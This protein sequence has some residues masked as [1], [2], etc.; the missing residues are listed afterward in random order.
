MTWSRIFFERNPSLENVD[1]R[2]IS[3]LQH[4]S[5]LPNLSWLYLG[6]DLAAQ[7]VLL[8]LAAA[9]Q[10]KLLCLSALSADAP[11]PAYRTTL[12]DNPSHPLTSWSSSL[13][14]LTFSKKA[15][16]PLHLERLEINQVDC[17]VINP[18]QILARCAALKSFIINPDDSAPLDI[19]SVIEQPWACVH[20]EALHMPLML[21]RKPI[22]VYYDYGTELASEED[23]DVEEEVEE[24][25]GEDVEEDGD[26]EEDEEDDEEER[27]LDEIGAPSRSSLHAEMVFM[28]RLST[29]TRL[30]WLRVRPWY[31]GRYDCMMWGLDSGLG[32]H[33]YLTHLEELDIGYR[34]HRQEEREIQWM[35]KNWPKLSKLVV[36]M[37]YQ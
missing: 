30:R 23:E 34:E 22:D 32:Q 3:C 8:I 19:R 11:K 28:V 13:I 29:L 24:D 33:Q 18:M 16:S 4:P 2:A 36:Y 20:L 25:E 35:R 5:A 26:V 31:P 15:H 1:T 12:Q 21:R 17:R 14:A 6:C 10:L 7:D 27:F 9:P 37:R